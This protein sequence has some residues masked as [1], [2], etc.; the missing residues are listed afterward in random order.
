MNLLD[1]DYYIDVKDKIITIEYNGLG[2][3]LVDILKNSIKGNDVEKTILY[4]V[5]QHFIHFFKDNYTF[6]IYHHTEGH[7]FEIL[8]YN[9][10]H[11]IKISDVVRAFKDIEE[12]PTNT[13]FRIVCGNM[14]YPFYDN[15]I[16]YYEPTLTGFFSNISGYEFDVNNLEIGNEYL[17]DKKINK[18]FI[19][20][21]RVPKKER[22]YLFHK[23][24]TEDKKL[25]DNSYWSWNSKGLSDY[26]FYDESH[27]IK[28]IEG[29]NKTTLDDES[30][31]FLGDDLIKDSFCSIISESEIEDTTLFL[32]EKIIKP[33]L[34]CQPFIVLGSYKYYD[35]LQKIGFKTFGE[36]WDE[37]FESVK[38]SDTADGIWKKCDLMYE[39]IKYINE[40]SLLEL[41]NLHKK[42]LPTL[43]HNRK[44][45]L[46]IFNDDFPDFNYLIKRDSTS[47][48]LHTKDK[49]DRLTEHKFE[50]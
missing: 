9:E 7:D 4:K 37:G 13:F 15:K 33:I 24:W 2:I 30:T 22:A 8:S 1:F 19:Y 31:N 39:Q 3:P 18:K 35:F 44:V 42:M 23:I 28:S 43:I 34:F 29:I 40:L 38:I 20:L 41:E 25:L 47:A 16:D 46:G 11:N 10:K 50:L 14:W 21:N 6:K 26:A 45:L 32:T 27:P 36:F 48:F 49:K 5:F 17:I 12:F